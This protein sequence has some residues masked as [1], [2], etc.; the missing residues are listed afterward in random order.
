MEYRDYYKILGVPRNAS[1][2]DIKKAYRQMARQYHPDMNPNDK[3]AEARFKEIN[4][5]YQV[6]SDPTKRARYDQLGASYQQWQN[7]G[8]GNFDWTQWARSSGGGWSS[9][10]RA[11][12]TR[13]EYDSGTGGIFSD[14]FNAI[15]GDTN[16]RRESAPKVPIR[17]NDVEVEVAISLEEAYQGT[18]RQIK[19][20]NQQVTV[21][22][23]R[24]ARDGLRVRFSKQG[25]RGFSGGEPGDLYVVV[26][27][28][29]SSTFERD[30]D[31]LLTEVKVPLYTAVL[32][33]DIRLTTLAGDIR[34]KIPPGT[35]SGQ[36][37]RLN[38][39][40]M[41]LLRDEEKS[42]DLYVR[43]LVQV[44]T[45]LSIEE[46]ELFEQLRDLRSNG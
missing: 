7:S 44:P 9:N 40:G 38:N 32:G 46:L 33:G 26:K 34:L 21:N 42:G 18:T 16:P 43:V 14:F 12:T 30:G 22:I 13:V 25:D 6:L 29:E 28:E 20:G 17:G 3:S 4:E 23:P 10:P 27:I 37:I 39:K 2:K 45:D 31:D 24:G 19:R 41:P 5:A 1:E 35:Q 15:F 8:Q 11:K 36:R